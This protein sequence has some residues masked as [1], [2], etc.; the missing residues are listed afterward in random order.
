MN[1]P[2]DRLN[3][4]W[5]TMLKIQFPFERILFALAGRRLTGNDR[6]KE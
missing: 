1:K 4:T 2:L 6:R 3:R 5:R